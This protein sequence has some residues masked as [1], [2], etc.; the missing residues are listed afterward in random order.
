MKKDSP[1]AILFLLYKMCESKSTSRLL[2]QASNA[3]G[4][5]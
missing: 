4:C 5:D 3:A 2:S 1:K